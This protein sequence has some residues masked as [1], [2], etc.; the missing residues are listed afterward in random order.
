MASFLNELSADNR[1]LVRSLGRPQRHP[2]RTVLLNQGDTSRHVLLILRGRIK[3]SLV[4]EDGLEVIIDI[5][6]EGD[7]CGEMEAI[8][9]QPRTATATAF[10]DCEVV[11][12][13]AADFLNL[14]D[15]HPEIAR[16]VLRN[17]V[18][19]LRAMNDRR[20]DASQ[21]GPTR[22]ARLLCDLADRFFDTRAERV[23]ITDLS[24]GQLAGTVGISDASVEKA[25]RQLRDDGIL[26]T[27]Y[28][29]VTIVSMTRLRERAWPA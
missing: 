17:T 23:E 27:S 9:P 18:R 21:D 5:R 3:V 20:L 16:A 8:D 14:L 24:Q 6:A 11:T 7:I 25:L 10:N 2:E 26:R 12:I 19:R 1:R 15:H 22:L 4:S 13:P 29:K 28:R